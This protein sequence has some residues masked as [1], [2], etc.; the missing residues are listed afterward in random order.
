MAFFL[1]AKVPVKPPFRGKAPSF[2]GF[3]IYTKDFTLPYSKKGKTS[4]FISRM[5][6]KLRDAKVLILKGMI[7]Y[8]QFK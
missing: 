8:Y 1:S 5:G 3:G 6:S 2:L 7:F 4:R